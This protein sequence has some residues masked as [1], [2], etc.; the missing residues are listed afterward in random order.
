MAVVRFPA[1]SRGTI[2]WAAILLG[3][4]FI[5][6]WPAL[7]TYFWLDDYVLLRI[8]G[9]DGLPSFHELKE[10]FLP[11]PN[12]HYRPFA[13]PYW[14]LN[15]VIFGESAWGYHAVSLLMIALSGLLVTVIARQLRLSEFA[16]RAAGVI[17]VAHPMLIGSAFWPSIVFDNM[18]N[19]FTLAAVACAL[20]AERRCWLWLLAYASVALAVLSKESALVAPVI[21]VAILSVRWWT[22]EGALTRRE[23]LPVGG[24]FVMLAAYLLL[25]EWQLGSP[26]STDEPPYARSYFGGHLIKNALAY[27]GWFARP[28]LPQEI[29]P[30]PDGWFPIEDYYNRLGDLVEENPLGIAFAVGLWL[31][32]LG[33]G[34]RAAI[35]REQG[36]YLVGWAWLVIAVLPAL[37]FTVRSFE[38]YATMALP[39]FALMA[40]AALALLSRPLRYGGLALFVVMAMV[41]VN[42]QRDEHWLLSWEKLSE[43]TATDL[44]RTLPS[45]PADKDLL[46]FWEEPGYN[47][48]FM[49]LEGHYGPQFL[50]GEP[51]LRVFDG[52]A[53]RCENDSWVA[54]EGWYYK[55]GPIEPKDVIA[56]RIG[57]EG[58]VKLP[59]EEAFSSAECPTNQAAGALQRS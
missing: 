12:F 57:E 37:A 16:S 7:T 33:L 54:P 52:N 10:V 32:L 8:W 42:D 53:L 17:Y 41:Y 36:Q 18:A 46:L 2:A 4:T 27:S 35:R 43:R 14:R 34:V 19:L 25:R 29:R 5:V 31:T 24:L 6:W 15:Y 51:D 39:G 58:V 9:N 56:L 30:G 49:S 20:G 50:Y 3:L 59:L 38:W 22:R 28:F 40:A 47:W 44:Q 21:L 1:L 13:W 45:I 23:L 11:P 55:V 26:F 48:G